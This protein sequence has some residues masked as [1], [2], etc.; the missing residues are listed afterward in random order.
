[1][2]LIIISGRSGSGKSTA[3]QALED[4]GYYCI[5]NLPAMLMPD[6]VSHMLNDDAQLNKI[7]VCIDARNLSSNL[8]KVPQMWTYFRQYPEISVEL[9]YLDAS[10]ETL[11]QRYSSTR[12]RH[13]MAERVS[14]LPDAIEYERKLL[15]P[16][17]DLANIRIDT[18]RLSI[19]ELRDAIKLRVAD[20]AEQSLSL[21]FESFGFKHGVPLD[22]DIVFDMRVLP[23]PYWVTELRQF[24]GLDQPVQAFLSAA[25][26]VTEMIHDIK[27]YIE[28]WLPHFIKN[29]R[30][31]M[32]VGIGCTGGHHR[33]VFVAEQLA[34]Y[35]KEHM[36]NV[37]VRHRELH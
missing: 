14:N 20:R 9:V 37:N 19:Y 27:H 26:E 5:D 34:S 3:L 25:P 29:N 12:R 23:N 36:D 21:Q 35:F 7:A 28:K 22:A 10:Y 6:L 33:S 1:M 16:I 18:T 32:T 8:E 31:Y 24:T 17:T 2:K 30:S 11:L 4:V 13:P 15:E